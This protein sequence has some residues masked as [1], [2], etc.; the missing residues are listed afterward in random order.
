MR[1]NVAGITFASTHNHITG[2]NV[3]HSVGGK[4]NKF[5][6]ICNSDQLSVAGIFASA[7]AQKNACKQG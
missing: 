2:W 6:L 3:C 7:E 5:G 4:G 1:K